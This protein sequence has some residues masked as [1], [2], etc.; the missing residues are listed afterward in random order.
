LDVQGYVISCTAQRVHPSAE[1]N[2]E[3]ERL[4]DWHAVISS[5]QRFSSTQFGFDVM[6]RPM[7]ITPCKSRRIW[8]RQLVHRDFLLPSLPNPVPIVD[9]HATNSR[10]FIACKRI[11]PAGAVQSEFQVF[12]PV[13]IDRRMLAQPL[14]CAID[15]TGPSFLF[16]SVENNCSAKTDV[17]SKNVASSR[18]TNGNLI[19]ANRQVPCDF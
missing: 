14:P 4:S 2:P 6:E 3:P 16:G 13:V 7:S 8:P 12:D 11:S 5:P 1:R 17:V 9:I 10:A 19:R 15:K 18:G